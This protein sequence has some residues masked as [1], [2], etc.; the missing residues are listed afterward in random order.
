MIYRL[1][2][3]NALRVFE[4]AARHLSFKEAANELSITQAAVSHQIKSLEE[5]LGVELFRRAG[6]GVQLT[7]AA[8][9]CLP[10]LREGF[11][12]LA[13]AMELLRERGGKADL[14]I[15]AP[16][17]F[18]ARWLM[19]RLADFS[20][21][22]PKVELRVFASSK[23]VDAGALDSPTLVSN[24]DLRSETSG[25]EIHLGNGH[26][27]GFRA[28]HLFAV[29]MTVVAAP[30]LVNGDPPLRE[31]ADLA[32]HMLLHDDAME[33]VTGGNAW[34]R[35][36]EAAG[37]ADRVDASRGPRFS[38]NI[39]SLEAASQKLGVA[40]ALRPLVDLDIAS[41]R[42]VAPFKIETKPPSAYYLVCA[43]VIADRP[44]VA[45]FRAWL[46]KQV[47]RV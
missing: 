18:T 19:P 31:P 43:E 16:P 2:S 38:T 3:L 46:L 17:V 26:Y 33:I 8:R 13:S 1:P 6:R 45:A 5:Y 23:M 24:L 41:G 40:L 34:Q 22:N 20:K 11:D 25:V 29:G 28:D 21:R 15:T 36:L 27:P 30:E 44:A 7:E 37:V 47:E 14:L 12:S 39:L 9:A 4:A 10:R 32:K 35:W 42:L